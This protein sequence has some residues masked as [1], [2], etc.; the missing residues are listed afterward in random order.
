MRVAALCVVI[1]LAVSV[2]Q[3]VSQQ[4]PPTAAPPSAQPPAEG[5]RGGGGGRGNAAAT[6]FTNTCAPCHGTDLAGARAPT[7]FSERLLAANDDG[8]LAAK[9]RDGVP[10]T[11]MAPF[12]GTL[13]DQQIWQ[14]V[15]YIR[16]AAANLKDKPV[17]VPDPDNQI[18]TSERQTFRI[19]VVAPGLE[20]PWGFAF[21][22]D[23]RLLVT[24]RP[25]RLRII[26]KGKLV[27]E[28]VRGTATVWERQD[29]GMLDVAVH[30]Q[31][32]KN[33]WIYL[34]YTE[35]VAG[36][37]APP[38]APAAPPDPAAATA[39]RGRGRGGPPSPPSM[40]V[41]VR[42]RID[43]SSHWV[44]EQLIYRAP[45]ELYTPSGSHYGTRF[46]FD[47]SGHVFYSLGE[48]GDMTNAQDLSKPLG[49]I[50]RVNDDGSIPKDN[51]FVNTPNAL[52]SIWSYGHRN[53]QGLARDA[54]GRLWESE[55]GP[56]GGD[57]INIIEKGKNYGW[58]VISMG[59]QNGITERSH[60]GMEQPIVYYT[61]TIAPSGISFYRG[62]KYPGWKNNL[63]VAALAGQQLRRLEISGRNVTH[64]EAVFQQFG[65]VRAVTTGP[66][67][68]LYVLLQNPTGAGTGVGLSASTP[69]MVIRLVPVARK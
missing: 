1:G 62:A 21:L 49:K 59:I 16:T 4:T 48:R 54:A 31:Y 55:H 27:A 20:T 40:T 8:A 3:A 12:K 51:P 30:P 63:F 69:G 33:G 68:L 56:T 2:Q 23:G 6:L 57:E 25:G 50:H 66:D 24:E 64:Q 43:K 14:L 10:N 15:A 34:A 7:L 17:F 45:A 29:A 41:F 58:G 36:Y 67:G 53:P 32:A 46:L 61:P 60:P 22:P 18:I 5:G 28:P 9:I 42:G 19:E 37:V 38:P 26:D 39:G 52:P 35:V 65:R 47:K 13:D 44:D 11:A